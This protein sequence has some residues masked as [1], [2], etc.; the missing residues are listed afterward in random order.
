[1]STAN[2]ALDAAR[3]AQS[4]ADSAMDCCNQNKSR[5]DQMFE[6]SMKK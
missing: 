2:Q 6:K 4:S 3:A 5:L 1:M